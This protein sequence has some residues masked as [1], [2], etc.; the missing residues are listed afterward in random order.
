MQEAFAM[1]P[2]A[3]PDLTEALD[4]LWAKFLPELQE[5][6][7]LLER[8]NAA[9]AAGTLSVELRAKANAAAHKLAGVLGTFGLTKG[10]VLAQEAE[11]IYSGEPDTDP[12]DET[13]LQQIA[14]GLRAVLASRK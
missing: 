12:A 1:E 9:L 6:V 4:S 14:A 11:I 2:M 10:T 3:R 7:A 13:H 8:A 5:R